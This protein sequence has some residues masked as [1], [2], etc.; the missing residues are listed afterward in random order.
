MDTP[1][2]WHPGSGRVESRESL[3]IN[4]LPDEIFSSWLVR[5]AVAQGC[6]PHEFTESIWSRFFWKSDMDLRQS[7][8]HLNLLFEYSGIPRSALRN[9]TMEPI[10]RI[11]TGGVLPKPGVWPW[12]LAIGTGEGKRRDG[13]QYCPYCLAEDVHPYFRIQWRLAWHTTCVAHGCVLLDA[14]PVCS[15]PVDLRKIDSYVGNVVLCST[16]TADLRRA[17]SDAYSGEAIKFQQEADR[18]FHEQSGMLYQRQ[19]ATKDWFRA[20]SVFGI[21][22]RNANLISMY[23]LRRFFDLLGVNLPLIGK[24]SANCRME[25]LRSEDRR[26]LFEGVRRVMECERG[27]I[28]EALLRAGLSQ[29]GFCRKGIH[30]PP[31]LGELVKTLPVNHWMKGTPQTLSGEIHFRAK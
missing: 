4:L 14:C 26:K 28:L 15:A 7:D 17:K 11:I 22:I 8:V 1:Y 5:Y 31:V 21:L 2:S 9:S 27:K 13:L 19:V 25:L 29:A 6:C 3:P 12:V 16:C 24:V 20:A 30:V 10:G 18:I 23:E